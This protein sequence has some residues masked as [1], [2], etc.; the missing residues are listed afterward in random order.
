MPNKKILQSVELLAPALNTHIARSAILSGADAIYIGPPKFGART[1]AANSMKDIEEL[2]KFAHQFHAKVFLT[3]NTLL[4]E[5]ELKEAEQLAHEA[6]DAGVDALIV[7]DMAYLNMQLPP[8]ELHASTQTTNLSASKVNALHQ[9][10]FA[11]VVL[12]RAL[13]LNEIVNISSN[14][15]AELEAFI[16][17]A[18]CV[19]YSGACTLSGYLANGRGGNRGACAQSCRANYNLLDSTGR[20][21]RKNEPLLSVQDFALGGNI[22]GLVEA[23][24]N[25]LKIEG[26]L[27]DERY[28]VNNVAYYDKILRDN[29]VPRTSLG[30]S[31]IGFEPNPLKSFS[32]SSGTYFFL[33][34]RATVG[35]ATK[36]LG[37]TIG[38]V[39]KINGFD[40]TLDRLPFVLNN[41]DGVCWSDGTGQ[42]F[43]AN[44]NGTRGNILLLS[45]LSGIKVGMTIYR[46]LDISFKPEQGL[47]RQIAASIIVTDKEIAAQV[48]GFELVSLGLEYDDIAKNSEAARANIIK[49]LMKSGDTI[50]K[51]EDVDIQCAEVPFIPNSLLAS[52]RR[53]LLNQLT[54]S[55]FGGYVRRE[56]T[57]VQA[58]SEC[59]DG[60]LEAVNISNSLASKFYMERGFATMSNASEVS[61]SYTDIRLMVS[62]Y[63]LRRELGICG[64]S[65]PLYLENNGRTLELRF[66]CK[67]CEMSIWAK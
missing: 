21:L 50:F 26:R 33:D 37:E 20:L 8:I 11:R 13:T 48:E 31:E 54:E 67:L 36:S 39:Q 10:G 52:L 2:C 58:L 57:G 18:I 25:S 5:E 29:G 12:E 4:L 16:H 35:A 55:I 38:T 53:E 28:V 23:G 60:G 65:T 19:G 6:W 34:K 49:I 56:R 43:G 30:R 40:I 46:N 66:D 45:N 51:I 3:T 17:G 63:C 41:G 14:T 1:A 64:D 59:T 44:I 24:V 62:R 42:V 22:M 15:K 9:A 61:N 27:K 7:Q 47:R 32:R